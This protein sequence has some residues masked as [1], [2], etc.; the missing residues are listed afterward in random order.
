MVFNATMKGAR[1]LAQV[2]SVTGDAALIE[3]ARA[4]VR[5]VVRHQHHNG[6]WSYSNADARTWVDNFHTGYILDCLDEYISLSGDEE[7]K[8]NLLR[9]FAFYRNNFFAEGRIPKYY[10]VSRYPIDSTA[11]AQ[12]ILTLCRF[13]CADL[14]TRVALWMVDNMQDPEGFFYY[15]WHKCYRNTISYMRWSNAWMFVALANLLLHVKRQ[16]LRGT[17][18]VNGGNTPA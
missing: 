14:A 3:D 6:A 17:N 8:P 12:S 11:A 18:A 4:T 15:Q 2:Y 16:H 13:D 1:L 5:F 9:G 7:F 10:D